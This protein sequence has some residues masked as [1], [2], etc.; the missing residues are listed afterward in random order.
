[1]NRQQ[2]PKIIHQIFYPFYFNEIP[3]EW[4]KNIEIWR[5]THPDYQYIL[6][7]YNNSKDFLKN[8]YPWF[9]DTWEK[10]HWNIQKCDSIRY[11]IL[12]HYGGIYCDLD[13]IP[14]RNIK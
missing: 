9:L 4:L 14:N 3:P 6:W 1:M 5:N 7:D 8:N 2:I 11:F 12:Y 10:Y 13:N